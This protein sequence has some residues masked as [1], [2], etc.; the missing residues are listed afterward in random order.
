MAYIGH[1]RLEQLLE[2]NSIEALDFLN[3]A[4]EAQAFID[5]KYADLHRSTLR[6]VD[7]LAN[8][9][10]RVYDEKLKT[11]ASWR[12]AKGLSLKTVV[13]LVKEHWIVAAIVLFGGVGSAGLT[14]VKWFEL[15]NATDK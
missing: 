9:A 13:T 8:L 6:K 12:E 5:G 1:P 11:L 14:A 4:G 15:W 2:V 3:G 10:N 7:V